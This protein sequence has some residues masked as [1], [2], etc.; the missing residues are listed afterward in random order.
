MNAPRKA[1]TALQRLK[2]F[3]AAKGVCHICEQKIQVGEA[4]DVE[5]K[6]PLSMGGTND[7]A[8]VAPAHLKCHS[9]KSGKETTDRAKCDRIRA[10]HIG[11]HKPSGF[12]KLPGFKHNWRTGRMEKT[13]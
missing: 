3:E 12:R 1:F 5:H 8:N 9:A 6:R 13:T 2:I 10:K 11:A 7:P 4:W